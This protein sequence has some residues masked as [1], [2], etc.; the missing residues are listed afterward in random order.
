MSN[1]QPASG[2]SF[3]RPT[4]HGDVDKKL[5]AGLERLGN[6]LRVLLQNAASA[7]GLSPIQIRMLID[8]R[9]RAPS[10]RRVGDLAETFGLT[11][12]TVSDALRTLADKGLVAKE[13]DP[14]D[15]RARIV[16]LTTDG[17]DVADALSTWAAPIREHLD[18]VADQRKTV[19]L[20]TIMDLIASLEAAGLV[21]RT[22][23]CKTCRFF[24]PDA[25]V[26]AGAPHHCRL[27]DVP[28][29]PGDLRMDCPEHEQSEA[30]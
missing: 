4:Q 26:D 13:P 23:M 18:D 8:L 6:V 5:V 25:H 12:P 27:L 11:P 1:P 2:S 28:L 7:H 15:R 19:T 3:H 9:F 21:S 14:A 24:A 22:R 30:T 17:R 16:R 10:G 20:N 29:R